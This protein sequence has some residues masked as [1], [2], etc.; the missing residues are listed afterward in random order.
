MSDEEIISLIKVYKKLGLAFCDVDYNNMI[1]VISAGIDYVKIKEDYD[2]KKYLFDYHKKE[3][4]YIGNDW[5]VK[6]AEQP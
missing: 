3:Y 2:D 6:K 4:Q 1:R 5:Y